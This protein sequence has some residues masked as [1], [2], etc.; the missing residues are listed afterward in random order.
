MIYMS[1]Q[2]ALSWNFRIIS[3]FS[4][5]SQINY[6]R[7]EMRRDLRVVRIHMSAVQLGEAEGKL[8]DVR[9][10]KLIHSI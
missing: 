1:R 3:G 5:S 7:E 2:E 9:I 10:K 8:Q 6:W 4:F